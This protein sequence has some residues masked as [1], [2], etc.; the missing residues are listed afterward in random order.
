MPKINDLNKKAS[1]SKDD[2]LV[3]SDGKNVYKT[4]VADLP[5]PRVDEI[6]GLDEAI[7]DAV[8]AAQDGFVEKDPT[9]PAWAKAAKKPTYT[10]SEVGA[11]PANTTV[12]QTARDTDPLPTSGGVPF[13]AGPY[14]DIVRANRLAFLPADQVVI[15]KTT[16]GGATWED[17]GVSD[18]AKA[19][20][21]S[22]TRASSIA[23]PQIDGMKNELCGLRI[24]ITAMKYNI[25]EGTAEADK[26]NYWN[27]NYV[28]TTERYCQIRFLYFWL[29]SSSESMHLKITSCIGAAG[30]TY[31]KIYDSRESGVVLTGWSGADTINLGNRLFGGSTSQTSQAWNYCFEFFTYNHKDTPMAES[32]IHQQQTIMAIH[33]Y[34]HNVWTTPNNLMK[35]DHMYTWDRDQNVTFPKN[36]TTTGVVQAQTLKSVGRMYINN[37]ELTEAKLKDIIALK[38]AEALTKSSIETALG[39]TPADNA[40][41]PEQR[42]FVITT[43]M[44]T[45]TTD[46]TKGVAPYNTSYGYTNI[47]ISADAGIKWVEGAIYQF[48]LT[49]VIGESANRNGRIRIGSDGAWIPICSDTGAIVACYSYL[50]STK[51]H[52]WTYKSNVITTGAL[53]YHTDTNS[54]Y[55]YLVNTIPSAATGSATK[56][57][58]NGYTPRYSLIFATTPLMDEN[59]IVADE[60]WSSLIASSSTDT[61]KKAVTPKSGKF[62]IDRH[63][64]YVASAAITAGAGAVNA[65]YQ[66]YAGM[67]IRYSVNTNATYVST[68]QKLYLWL[69]DF[70]P[71]DMSFHSDATIGNIMSLDKISTRFPT[72]VEGDVYLYFLGWTNG[73]T[74]NQ[75]RPVFTQ[76]QRIYKY[77]P[78][79]KAFE[80]WQPL[81]VTEHDLMTV[82]DLNAMFA[83][84]YEGE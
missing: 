38:P 3:V 76:K 6:D 11:M 70:D 2:L 27:A 18:A 9:V 35:L 17:A 78:S 62:Y 4:E 21:F 68:Y 49:A 75:L 52:Q 79:T 55:D 39:Y 7:E 45:I 51:S 47:E 1:I 58:D 48:V 54:T 67:D 72:T 14:I 66:D 46:T 74:W 20:L 24:Y 43:D 28:K 59:G 83:G 81:T 10:A 80:A 22:E 57:D 65:T 61:T 16:D 69:K 31:N 25:P 36:I 77:T 13:S 44:L 63:P 29:T 84:T 5:I 50:T 56:I 8:K 19:N 33:G 34:G 82:D 12:I 41:L 40:A 32:S 60:R 15:L 53:C 42:V 64:Q 23:L 73:S 30:S 71:S 37:T 26:L